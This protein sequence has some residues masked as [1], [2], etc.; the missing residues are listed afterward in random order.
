MTLLVRVRA[1]HVDP[2]LGDALSDGLD[3]ALRVAV[4]VHDRREDGLGRGGEE[5]VLVCGVG[6]A[7]VDLVEEEVDR[8]LRG[9]D[10]AVREFERSGR[11][12]DV[13]EDDGVDGGDGVDGLAE[14]LEPHRGGE[15]SGAGEVGGHGDVLHVRRDL[16]AVELLLDVGDGQDRRRELAEVDA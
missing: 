2:V 12:E 7:E 9:E 3:E 14:V 8:V 10:R 13:G 11:A 15:L 5:E 6:V 1:P 16:L 4:E